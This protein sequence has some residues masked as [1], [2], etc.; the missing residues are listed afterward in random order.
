MELQR[1]GPPFLC[2]SDPAASILPPMPT[3]PKKR[4]NT[5]QS[6][7]EGVFLVCAELTRRGYI[8]SPTARNS[9]G[10]DILVTSADCSRS[11]AVQVKTNTKPASFWL[12][13]DPRG[14]CSDHLVYIFVCLN[15]HTRPADFTIVPSRILRA[16]TR[17]SDKGWNMF[18]PGDKHEKD[19]WRL[20]DTFGR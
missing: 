9:K 7:M 11:F 2:L 13:D 14:P 5:Q 16:Q 12:V 15:S 18:F 10:A 6:G 4:I 19:N 20:L 8:A 17:T 3:T 1:K